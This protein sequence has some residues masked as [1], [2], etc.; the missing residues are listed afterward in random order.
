[1]QGITVLLLLKIVCAVAAKRGNN[2][3]VFYLGISSS[4]RPLK[5]NLNTLRGREDSL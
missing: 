5:E 2:S 4:F 3:A 1:M